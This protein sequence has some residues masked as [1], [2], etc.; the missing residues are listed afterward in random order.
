MG[1]ISYH[2]DSQNCM[3][4]HRLTR[5]FDNSSKTATK[6]CAYCAT[7]NNTL[8]NCKNCGAPVKA[9]RKEITNA[10]KHQILLRTS[11][12]KTS[13][14]SDPIYSQKVVIGVIIFWII[15]SLTSLVFVLS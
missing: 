10:I 2:F 3:T 14:C 9:E 8:D 6:P 1:G 5:I 7:L 11:T 12:P 15:F 4:S 13:V